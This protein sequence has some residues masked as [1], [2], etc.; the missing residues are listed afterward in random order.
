MKTNLISTFRKQMLLVLP[1]VCFTTITHA[2]ITNARVVFTPATAGFNSGAFHLTLPDSTGFSEVEV[3]LT[4]MV[5]DTIIFNGIYFFD[6]TSGLPSGWSW[7]R[8]GTRITM[9]MGLL[10]EGNAWRGKTR[11]KTTAGIWGD[12]LFFLFN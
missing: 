8:E 3:Q 10:P 7:A 4:E 5:E 11:V 2:Q 1:M 6:Q 9:G 12:W